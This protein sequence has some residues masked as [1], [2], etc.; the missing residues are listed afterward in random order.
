MKLK[1]NRP[2]YAFRFAGLTLSACLLSIAL[3]AETTP[4]PVASGSFPRIAIGGEIGTA[5][6]GPVAV[7][8]A[9]EHFTAN[10]G[11]TWLNYD[12]D[13]SYTSGD[14]KAKLN[15]SNLQAIINWHPFAGSFHLSAGA[16]LSDDKI[17]MTAAP[18][19]DTTYP[20]GDGTYTATQV[21][22]LTG[23]AV[24]SNG[25][26][27]LVGLGW[28][29]IPGKSGFGVFFDIGVLFIHSPTVTFIATGPITN[30][31]TFKADLAKETQT[32]NDDLSKIKYYPIIK[33]G[34][35]YRF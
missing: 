3:R 26:A 11:Y 10:V 14:Y 30:D 35:L 20:I 13:R 15:L 17:S 23:K 18:K 19:G 4:A 16:F 8:T 12:F 21:G 31:T 24:L 25:V 9:S 29:K 27:P 7:L 32:V 1:S 33:F 5:G 22:T 28:S 2:S 6:W 34:V